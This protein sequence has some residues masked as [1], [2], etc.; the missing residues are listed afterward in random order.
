MTTS[1]NIMGSLAAMPRTFVCWPM[2]LLVCP[3]PRGSYLGQQDSAQRA[4]HKG[5]TERRA[6]AVSVTVAA[7]RHPLLH[8][9]G[10]RVNIEGWSIGN[11]CGKLGQCGCRA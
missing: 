2:M 9:H 4:P 5:H 6:R 7:V 8:P 3:T 10:G 1:A 11:L